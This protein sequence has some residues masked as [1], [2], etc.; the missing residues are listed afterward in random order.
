MVGISS[1]AGSCD[2]KSN[3]I[4]KGNCIYGPV[5][6]AFIA[7][8]SD[9]ETD[10]VRSGACADCGVRGDGYPDD[11]RSGSFRAADGSA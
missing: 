4:R 5:R 11:G 3:C 1:V 2:G 6:A 7:C 10:F 9:L 8:L